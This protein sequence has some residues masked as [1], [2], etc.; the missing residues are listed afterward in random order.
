MLLSRCSLSSRAPG[1]GRTAA[2]S[3]ILVAACLG[4]VEACGRAAP[5]RPARAEHLDDTPR[6]VAAAASETTRVVERGTPRA[7]GACTY[8]PEVWPAG[9]IGGYTQRLDSLDRLHCVRYW[10][11]WPAGLRAT[12]AASAGRRTD[13]TAF[14]LPAVDTG[15]APVAPPP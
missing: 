1:T 2:C 5:E 15:R 11:R 12:P 3:A 13:T 10:T 7:D 6:R 8:P 9:R 14:R 4:A